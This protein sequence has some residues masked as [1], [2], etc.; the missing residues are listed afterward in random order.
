MAAWVYLC[1]PR[2]LFEGCRQH[3]LIRR[4]RFPA[5]KESG[6]TSAGSES[7]EIIT[8]IRTLEV[9]VEQHWTTCPAVIQICEL[10]QHSRIVG[11]RKIA[12]HIAQVSVHGFR[13]DHFG[14]RICGLESH[15]FIISRRYICH[16][17][18]NK[19]KVTKQAAEAA[20]MRVAE[21]AVFV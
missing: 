17:C 21:A 3:Q 2:F 14:R 6:V 1:L 16:C 8:Y 12:G 10:P 20:G 18:E 13:D 5:A 7:D 19:A 11:E 9:A 15:Y 4:Q